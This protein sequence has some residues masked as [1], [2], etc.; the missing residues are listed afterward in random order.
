MLENLST[1]Q[2]L[3]ALI[4][5]YFVAAG[6]GL[7]V[8]RQN[9]SAMFKDLSNHAMLGYLGGLIAFTIGGAMVAIHNDWSGLL[10]GFVTLVGWMAL[11]EG[12]MMLAFRKWFLELFENWLLSPTV[13]SGFGVGTIIVG[14][15]VL[16]AGLGA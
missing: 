11:F 2:T 7:L 16:Y 14:A 1:T 5:L 8:E 10:A 15:I 13:V 12:V 9:M 3:A 6:T 4:G